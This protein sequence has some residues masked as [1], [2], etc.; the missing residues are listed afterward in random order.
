M[1]DEREEEGTEEEAIEPFRELTL[2]DGQTYYVEARLHPMLSE[3][4]WQYDRVTEQVVRMEEGH[5][6]PL[7][8]ERLRWHYRQRR[9]ETD[10]MP[11][12]D[13]KAIR[14]T[15]GHLPAFRSLLALSQKQR[16]Y[17]TFEGGYNLPAATLFLAESL[18]DAL[19]AY[20][21][22]QSHGN[23]WAFEPD[24]TGL[25]PG[26]LSLQPK[27]ERKYETLGQWMASEYTGDWQKSGKTATGLAPQTFKMLIQRRM[28][29]TWRELVKNENFGH[30]SGKKVEKLLRDGE[31]PAFLTIRYAR[32]LMAS[33][34]LR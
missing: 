10:G 19:L 11:V 34:P 20:F 13:R 17:T 14:G 18:S 3:W 15:F 27:G 8:L 26:H 25:T 7:Y 22:W 1:F 6:K 21:D 4:D 32:D 16:E 28:I 31:R 5:A 33:Y 24:E 23:V 30:V 12:L 29:E 9:N 2:P